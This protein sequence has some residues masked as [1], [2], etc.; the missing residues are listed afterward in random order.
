MFPCSLP[1]HQGIEIKDHIDLQNLQGDFMQQS[2]QAGQVYCEEWQVA[3]G[4]TGEGTHRASIIRESFHHSFFIKIENSFFKIQYTLIMVSFPSSPLSSSP[5]L[6]PPNS[7]PFFLSFLRKETEKQRK[8]KNNKVK[9]Q[10][11]NTITT[12][13]N[14]RNTYTA[15]WKLRRTQ[16]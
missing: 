13:K 7:K 4:L 10:S 2:K 12:R 9:Y 3:A 1:L 15:D 6:Y 16:N 5:P 14:L 8:R 11:T